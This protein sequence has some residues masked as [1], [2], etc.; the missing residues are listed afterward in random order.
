MSKIAQGALVLLVAGAALALG[1]WV[2]PQAGE[3]TPLP[4]ASS[5]EALMQASLPDLQGQLQRI[6]QWRGKVLVVN[7][8]AT[9]CAP[10]REEIPALMRVQD[11]LGPKG[12]Q[13]VGIAIDQLDK[14]QPYAA[15]LKINYPILVGELDAMQL[16][17]HAGNR[18]GGLPYTVILNRAGG[19]ANAVV[20]TVDD[21]KL[22]AIVRPL[23]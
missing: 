8:W 13:M 9:W 6:G 10:C 22:H 12:V 5:A 21:A 4:G 15:E 14:V 3:Q 18:L 20:G 11:E 16:A 2:R 1:W 23:L 17:Q 19:V 7:F